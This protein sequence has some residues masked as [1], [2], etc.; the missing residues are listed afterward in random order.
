LVFGV[1]SRARRIVAGTADDGAAVDD[2]AADG[3]GAGVEA[4]AGDTTVGAQ[5][6]TASIATR[7]GTSRRWNVTFELHRIRN[8]APNVRDGVIDLDVGPASFAGTSRIRFGGSV[9]GATLSAHEALPGGGVRL[10]QKP[11]TL[12]DPG[13][14]L[15]QD[16]RTLRLVVELMTKARVG[17]SLDPRCALEYL[18]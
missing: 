3:A 8:A 16:R 14:D 1:Q 12:A 4:G 11:S 7:I 2:E 10:W 18:G 13:D 15:V 17:P 5:A 9:A 6:P